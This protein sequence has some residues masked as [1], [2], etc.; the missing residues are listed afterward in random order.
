MGVGQQCPTSNTRGQSDNSRLQCNREKPTKRKAPRL[1]IFAE[2]TYV[3]NTL[4]F[5]TSKKGQKNW[6]SSLILEFFVSRFTI[7]FLCFIPLLASPESVNATVAQSAKCKV[8][9]LWRYIIHFDGSHMFNIA[10]SLSE[11][12]FPC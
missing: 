3:N 10:R 6:M 11:N 2:I 12:V 7:F 9:C 4:A 5:F 1:S 8:C